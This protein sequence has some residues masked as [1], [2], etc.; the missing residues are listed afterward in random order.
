YCL[1]C[2]SGL[3]A[4]TECHIRK[5]Y[6]VETPMNW[7]EAQKYCREKYTDLA[8]VDNQTDQDK[9]IN[10]ERNKTFS[11][12]WIGLYRL[13]NEPWKWSDG[14]KS[15]FRNWNKNEPNNFN[16]MEK[17]GGFYK[18]G[19]WNDFPCFTSL[20]FYCEEETSDVTQ[21]YTLNTESKNWATARDY[22]REK[23]TDLVTI[24]NHSENEAMRERAGGGT[25]WIGLFNEPWK[26]S[27]G[28]VSS[29]RNWNTNDPNNFYDNEKCVRLSYGQKWLDSS[30]SITYPFFCQEGLCLVTQCDIRKYHNV[31]TP[32][33]WTKAQSYCR[34][35]Y[36]DLATV[37]NLTDQDKMFSATVMVPST[38]WI[39]LYRG[40]DNWLWVSGENANYN[41]WK[42]K[43]FCA[44]VVS[45]GPWKDLI[46]DE[47][48]PFMCYTETSDVS[49][50]YTLITESKNWTTARDYCREKHTDL[51]TIS[52]HSENEIVK[53]RTGGSTVWI[54]LF[55]EPWKW[56]DGGMSSFRNW[57]EN[58]PNNDHNQENCGGL[59]PTGKWNDFSCQTNLTF[60]CQED[61]DNDTQRYTLI[62]ENRNWT[63]ARDYC[64][65]Q[66]TGL[67]TI[68]SPRENDAVMERGQG[69]VFWI[70]LFNDPW[71]WSNGGE[72]LFRNW[73]PE[74]PSNVNRSQAC[75]LMEPTLGN[76]WSDASCSI[77]TGFICCDK[78]SNVSQS[79]TLINEGKTWAAARD[80]CQEH[81][82]DL[83]TIRDHSE[84]KAVRERAGFSNAWIGL[85]NEPWKWSDQ[86][87]LSFRNWNSY[88]PNNF[89]DV[90]KCAG[91]LA[92][93]KWN[94]CPCWFAQPF[95]CEEDLC[96]VTQCHIRKQHYVE[97]PM[98][99]IKAQSY[100]REK[101]T[102][103]ST[104]D[105]QTDQDKLI[106]MLNNKRFKSVWIGLYRD[107]PNWQW[108]SGEEVTFYK[109]RNNRFCAKVNVEGT[110]EDDVCH[111]THFFMCYTDTD[112]VTQR[113]TLIRENRNW[114][115]A[116]DY[117]REQHTDLVTI[118]SLR[119]N[120]A[121]RKRGQDSVF[122]I[123]LF[124]E[125]WKW[126]SGAA[127]YFHQWNYGQPNFYEGKQKC[128]EMFF[129][130]LGQ[131]RWNDQN[132]AE[133]RPF[134]C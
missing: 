111:E 2:F 85:F 69:S 35:K 9:L 44:A 30:C 64:R 114:T 5:Y 112:N 86:G 7:T 125:P 79:Y 53:N 87:K 4:V 27:S 98:S 56:S 97:T 29:F 72:S 62:R 58:E 51:V 126:S 23:H 84:N 32:M 71:K 132:C 55:N 57:N 59:L 34:A 121:V 100:C 31:A 67:V 26:W 78:T 42:T 102:D 110:W 47:A 119:E 106:N 99:W 46:C 93:G 122:W 60:L 89:L 38:T 11:S 127:Y 19:K 52:N 95:C 50:R 81:H 117:C 134:L 63:A 109:W 91:F 49:Q 76:M 24:S 12:F 103:L 8:T 28:E 43:L 36:T 130:D 75:V 118:R 45:E 131:G 21:R 128:V 25:V 40:P 77:T 82:T 17:C 37:D 88:E 16:H 66:H 113:Y 61:T 80:Y 101:Y 107:Q 70:G 1:I 123:G 129:S 22:C 92:D 133:R 90:E 96:V 104:V 105:N 108:S 13:F 10:M 83:V 6:Y 120:D 73:A 48:H 39:G 15:S 68:R 14:E 115:A 18:G 116:R 3:F 20:P 33:S 65:E 74:R 54:G 41:D 94:D 124:N